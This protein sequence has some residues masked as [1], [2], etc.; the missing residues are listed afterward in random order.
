MGLQIAKDM[1]ICNAE[2]LA[3]LYSARGPT[4]GEMLLFLCELWLLD[5]GFLACKG[6]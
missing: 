6:P 1:R 3:R 2:M 4:G 5:F